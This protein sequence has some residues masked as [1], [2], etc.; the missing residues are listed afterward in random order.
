MLETELLD[1]EELSD[2][3]GFRGRVHADE[4]DVAFCHV[5]LH[6]GAEEEIATAAFLHLRDLGKKVINQIT[7]VQK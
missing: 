6:F 4:D 2:Y 3:P 7:N 1:G 5:L